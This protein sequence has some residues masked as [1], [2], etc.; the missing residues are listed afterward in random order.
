VYG[1]AVHNAYKITL[2]VVAKVPVNAVPF[3]EVA[4]PANWYPVFAMVPT[5][6]NV[7]SVPPDVNESLVFEAEPDAPFESNVTV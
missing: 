7:T 5:V 2:L 4:Q 1:I 6:A 3:A